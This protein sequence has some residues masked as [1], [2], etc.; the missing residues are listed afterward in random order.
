MKPFIRLFSLVLPAVLLGQLAVAQSPNPVR[1][2]HPEL[3]KLPDAALQPVASTTKL[4][5]A[6]GVR[7]QYQQVRLYNDQCIYLAP[8]WRGNTKLAP[9]KAGLFSSPDLAELDGMLLT[10]LNELAEAGW[11]L[12][13]VQ[14]SV[15]PLRAT[16]KQE[17]TL[18]YND[19]QQPTYTTTTALESLTQ[20][21]YLLRRPISK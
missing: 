14:T 4:P 2:R 20:T 5:A 12:V 6:N 17:T 11:E 3:P 8:A 18:A 21:R 15:Q 1:G 19:P 9:K 10:T 13:E 16:Q 7:Y